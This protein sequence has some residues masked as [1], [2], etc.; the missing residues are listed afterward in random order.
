MPS[1]I[2]DSLEHDLSEARRLAKENERRFGF[3]HKTRKLYRRIAKLEK[4][5]AEYDKQAEAT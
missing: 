3:N 5:L 2:R 1:F 4:R